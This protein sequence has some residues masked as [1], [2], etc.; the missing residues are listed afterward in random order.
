[1]S[2]ELWYCLKSKPRGEGKAAAMLKKDLKVSVFCPMM[3]FRRVRRTGKVWVTE[4]MFPGYLFCR[5]DYTELGRMVACFP[6]I[7]KIVSFSGRPMPVEERIVEELSSYMTD[8]EVVEISE[9]FV[10]GDE[11]KLVKGVFA[12]VQALVSR[13]LPA[14]Q[15]VVVLFELLGMMREIEVEMDQVV[16]KSLHPLLKEE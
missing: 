5:F 10:P 1:M 4:A 6:G 12:G 13:V 11:V 3:R 15:R 14:R 16:P 9:E 8:G 2:E 7:A